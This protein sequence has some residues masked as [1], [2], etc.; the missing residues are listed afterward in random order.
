MVSPS[1]CDW[2][3]KTPRCESRYGANHWGNCDWRRGYT[4]LVKAMNRSFLVVPHMELHVSLGPN[5]ESWYRDAMAEKT[6]TATWHRGFTQ[7]CYQGERSPNCE[8]KYWGLSK[9]SL[10]KLCLAQGLHPTGVIREH[11]L[12]WG[13]WSK[14]L[15]SH[16]HPDCPGSLKLVKFRCIQ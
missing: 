6:T 5:C 1:W 9:V 11:R 7:W 8:S 16:L 15:T 2:G 4:R 13:S 10:E 3:E 14:S 12:L